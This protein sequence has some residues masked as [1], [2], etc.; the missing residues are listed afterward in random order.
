MN[1]KTAASQWQFASRPLEHALVALPAIVWVLAVTLANPTGAFP[2]NDDWSYAQTVHRLLETG[3]FRP[4]GWTSMTLIGQVL[5]GALFCLPSGFSFESLRISTLVAGALGLFAFAALLRALGCS[6]RSMTLATLALGFNPLYFALSFTFMTDIGF[7]ALALGSTLNFCRYLTERRMR[8]LALTVVLCLAALSIR[9]T[10]LYLPAAMLLTLALER[11]R[12]FAAIGVSLGIAVASGAFLYGLRAF[13]AAHDATPVLYD[14]AYDT[15]ATQVATPGRLLLSAVL[16]LSA[17]AAYLGWF[18]FPVLV[19]RLPRTVRR[20]RQ[21]GVRRAALIAAGVAGLAIWIAMISLERSMPVAGNVIAATGIGPVLLS[22]GPYPAAFAL[23][24]AFW[25]FVTL[26][27]VAG[28]IMLVL[29]LSLACAALF[30]PQRSK[31]DARA[32]GVRVFLLS[33]AA[34]YVAPFLASHFY[35]R[36][37]LPVSFL[38]LALL[39]ID[40]PRNPA[41]KREPVGSRAASFAAVVTLAAMGLFS[42]MA[43]HDYMS[44]NRARWSLLDDLTARG[45]AADRIDGGFEF[46]GFYLYDPSYVAKPQRGFWWIY[47]NQY[48]VRF[49]HLQGYRE[50]NRAEFARWLAPREPSVL[51]LERDKTN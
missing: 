45:V 31:L 39:V 15:L 8:H 42:V 1:Q 27:S 18:L 30:A 4:L 50:V 16:K 47:D 6:R 10:A 43:T 13:L 46:N 28:A 32:R 17:L 7:T 37:L 41:R 24:H 26:I 3:Q 2:L 11:R 51:L 23:P 49:T 14:M 5:W 44:L 36:Y 21:W 33:S 38:L 12:D 19:W 22:D 35:D 48:V 34:I 9:Q 40:D 29:E 25:V 20:A